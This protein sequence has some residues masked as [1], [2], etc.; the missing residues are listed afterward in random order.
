MIQ[1]SDRPFSPR[2]PGGEC[3]YAGLPAGRRLTRARAR[4]LRQGAAGGRLV[5]VH[6]VPAGARHQ[7][8]GLGLAAPAQT[9]PLVQR[10]NIE[11]GK[12]LYLAIYKVFEDLY[13]PR[14]GELLV[15][16]LGPQPG[17]GL[18]Y[19]PRVCPVLV[20]QRLLVSLCR[21][22]AR[23]EAAGEAGVWSVAGRGHGGGLTSHWRQGVR[24]HPL[25]RLRPVMGHVTRVTGCVCHVTCHVSV[26]RHA[27]VI[28]AAH[29]GLG[30]ESS[31]VSLP[32]VHHVSLH[33]GGPV[34]RGR[35]PDTPVIGTI[36][37]LCWMK[38]A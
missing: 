5:A 7:V 8:R 12:I 21:C 15:R 26:P 36:C 1:F 37:T 23:V 3:V 18:G 38:G 27:G 24:Y 35:G 16:S 31:A 13:S 22:L 2:Q 30:A 14:W 34:D 25:H 20:T 32:P 4:Q 11:P 17:A 29:S 19:R 28:V 33:L 6:A 9:G 10:V